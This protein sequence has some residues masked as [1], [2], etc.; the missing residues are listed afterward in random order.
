[1]HQIIG[2]NGVPAEPNPLDT[3]NGNPP[4]KLPE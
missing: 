2:G 4:M 1:V 3:R